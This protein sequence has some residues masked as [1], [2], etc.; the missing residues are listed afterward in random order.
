MCQHLIEIIG[1][2]FKRRPPVSI[3]ALILV[4]AVWPS[5]RT[6]PPDPDSAQA[7]ELESR[8]AVLAHYASKLAE[9]ET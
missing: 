1:Q 3:A 7:L 8:P 2:D 6:L 9:A 4:S 5:S